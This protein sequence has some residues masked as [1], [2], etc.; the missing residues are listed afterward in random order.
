MSFLHP[1][2]VLGFHSC[3]KEVALSILYGKD[4]L[5]LSDNPWDWLGPG[6]Y[7]WEYDPHRALQYAKEC[8]NGQQKFSGFIKTPCVMGAIIDLGNCLNLVESESLNIVE[9]T[10]LQMEAVLRGQGEPMPQNKGA[11]RELDCAVIRYVHKINRQKNRPVYDSVRSSFQ[12]GGPIYKGAN[13]S[14]RSHLEICVLNP[15]LIK[16]Y[17]L[18]QPINDFN[19]YL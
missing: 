19:P 12:E 10:Y 14:R 6:I 7:F 9:E 1:P 2:Q 17:F 5:R 13:F 8:A 15:K 4:Q 18:P 16:G 11:N 3:E